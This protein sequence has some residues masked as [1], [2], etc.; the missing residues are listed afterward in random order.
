[1]EGTITVRDIPA[2]ATAALS[3]MWAE[4]LVIRDCDGTV[5]G[6]VVNLGPSSISQGPDDD[7]AVE[8]VDAADVRLRFSGSQSA[9]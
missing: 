4:Y 7:W 2:G 8:I 1:V 3:G 6:D 5:L 9:R